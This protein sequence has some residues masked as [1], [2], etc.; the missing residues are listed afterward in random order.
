MTTKILNTCIYFLAGLSFVLIPVSAFADCRMS[1]D[2]KANYFISPEGQTSGIFSDNSNRPQAPSTID[3]CPEESGHFMMF[4]YGVLRTGINSDVSDV[5]IDGNIFDTKC[6]IQNSPGPVGSSF[7]NE[8]LLVNTKLKA[9]RACTFLQV[10]DLDRNPLDYKPNQTTCKITSMGQGLVRA[11]GQYCF[12]R[13]RPNNRFA[14]NVVVKDECKDANYLKQNGINPQ[15]IEASLNAYV[16]GDDSGYSSDVTAI[17]TRQ[18]RF[19][20]QPSSQLM[21]LSEDNGPDVPRFAA[22]YNADIH[23]GDLRMAGGNGNT[24]GFTILPSL[25]VSNTGSPKCAQGF[26]AGPADFDVPVVGEFALYKVGANGATE[27][28]DSWWAGA[29]AQPQWQGLLHLVGHTINESELH[30]GDRYQLTVTF[31]D[32]YDD[33]TLYSK[34]FEQLMIDLHSTEGTAGIDTIAPIS[35]LAPLGGVSGLF[36]LPTLSGP[37]ENIDLSNILT[38]LRKLG[39]NRQWPTYYDNICNANHQSCVKSGK[40]KFFNKLTTNF[41]LG[42]YDASIDSWEIKNLS[43]ARQSPVFNNYSKGTS[44]LPSVQCGGQ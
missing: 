5:T 17:G 44:A 26:C 15:D 7:V 27:M 24:D 31:V 22:E 11:E 41:T 16:V 25:L 3:K 4:A 20:I 40:V 14:V 6:S 21:P 1:R 42:N 2:P 37:D 13:I 19:Y 12:F 38:A 23:M 29:L 30:T 36:G 18:M 33:F 32:P 35:S 28:I 34:Y 39:D 10:A 8:K 43:V 9:L